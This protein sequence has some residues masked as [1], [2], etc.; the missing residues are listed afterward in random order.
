[1]PPEALHVS[2][3]PGEGVVAR[4]DGTVLVADAVAADQEALLDA[5][6]S[7]DSHG[8]ARVRET[9]R[10]LGGHPGPTLALALFTTSAEGPSVL[11]SGSAELRVT[12]SEGAAWTLDGHEAVTYVDRRLPSDC[13]QVQ[14]TVAGSRA[15]PSRRSNLTGGVVAGSGAMLRFT[16]EPAGAAPA[17]PT[18]L[19]AKPPANS[20]EPEP[21]PA[22]EPQRVTE[23]EGVESEEPAT[24][25]MLTEPSRPIPAPEPVQ[26]PA[27]EAIDLFGGSDSDFGQVTGQVTDALP[28]ELLVDGHADV[29][30]VVVHGIMCS[31]GHFNRP[32]SRFCSLCGISMVHQTH[33]VV[34]GPR[35]PL[36]V[37]VL[38]D[39]TVHPLTRDLVLGREPAGADEVGAGTA[40][41]LA[42]DDPELA[43]SRVHARVVLDGW[44]VRVEDAGSSNGT[45][46]AGSPDSDWTRLEAGLPTTIAPGTRVRLGG[47]TLTFES[48]Q[49]S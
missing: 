5:L 31:R 44:D 28:A 14:L 3:L 17:P 20:P 19:T 43:M 42:L 48:H 11:L 18:T 16:R 49:R 8:D 27:F 46:V 37:L 23:P 39:G 13:L 1:M 22:T 33:N 12:P 25:P 38:D 7:L 29:A 24:E 45:F 2:V 47:R 21:Q 26:T 34:Q 32:D 30:E 4:D 15:E 41:A 10:L 36:G 6:L 40:V 35:P 9:A